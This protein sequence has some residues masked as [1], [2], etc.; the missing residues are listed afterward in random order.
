MGGEK[1]KM[2]LEN[3]F[4]VF[5]ICR[6]AEH[7]L[8]RTTKKKSHDLAVLSKERKQEVSPSFRSCQYG[9]IVDFMDLDGDMETCR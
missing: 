7:L 2:L 8:T 3:S 4:K 6:F 5:F 9:A 1:K